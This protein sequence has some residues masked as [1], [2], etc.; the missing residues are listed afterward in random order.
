MDHYTRY[1]IELLKGCKKHNRGSQ[2]AI[3]KL[4]YSFCMSIC[5]R[6]AKSREDAVEI[7]NDGF[8]KIFKYIDNFDLK[9]PFKPW[10]RKVMINSAIDHLKKHNKIQQMESLEYELKKQAENE[11]L[12]S[13]SYEDLLEIIRKLP[14]AYRIVFNM[15]AIEGY[16][17]EEIADHLGIS[18]GTSK[19]NYAKARTKLQEY[20]A[21]YFGVKQ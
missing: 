10:L 7:M 5:L 19:S 1:T 4:Y 2:Q 14:P 12:D 11:Q 8:M 20:L 17:H 6:Y 16:K 21:N 15:R 13:V 18:I 3:Y 9:K